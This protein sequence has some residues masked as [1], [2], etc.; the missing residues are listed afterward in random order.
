MFSPPPQRLSETT[1]D[2]LYMLQVR[3]VPCAHLQL[4]PCTHLQLL[5]CTHLQLLPCTHLQL[6]PCT[7][8][9][10]QDILEPRTNT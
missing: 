4:L 9:Q 3:R 2:N 7:H 8:L 10:L 1:I 6:L 5:P